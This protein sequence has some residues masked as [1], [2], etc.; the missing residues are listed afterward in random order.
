MYIVVW[1]V[2][3]PPKEVLYIYMGTYLAGKIKYL[4]LHIDVFVPTHC[5]LVL[6]AF[7]SYRI[8]SR[9]LIYSI[10]VDADVP[11]ASLA[12]GSDYLFQ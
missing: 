8:R 5:V 11:I 1:L 3:H 2:Q 6:F 12:S 4:Q 7:S 10:T 9:C